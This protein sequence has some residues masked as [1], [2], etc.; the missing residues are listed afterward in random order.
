[1]H[2]FWNFRAL[3]VT[4]ILLGKQPKKSAGKK[5]SQKSKHPKQGT[6]GSGDGG[7]TSQRSL[8][9][10]D[11]E[12]HSQ[13][14]E[15]GVGEFVALRLFKYNDE[16]PQ[17][18]K[19]VELDEMNVTIEWWIGTFRDIWRQWKEKKNVVK[20]TFHRNTIIKRGITFTKSMRLPG[21]LA[22]EL[23]KLYETV[24]MM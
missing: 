21:Q 24:E 18:G 20:E 16:I 23:K 13:I 3:F 7:N 4:Q 9:D 10:G 17:I 6:T 2:G 8:D 19:V 12:A 15:A 11:S 22:Q 5:T 1:M 14:G